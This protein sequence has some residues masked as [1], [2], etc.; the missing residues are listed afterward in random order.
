M[1]GRACNKVSCSSPSSFVLEAYGHRSPFALISFAEIRLPTID[2]TPVA[3]A[4]RH[5][6]DRGQIVVYGNVL[7]V[8]MHDRGRARTE[9]HRR[10]VRIAVEETR[11]RGALTATDLGGG[12]GNLLV[13]LGDGFHD[14]MIPRDF[15]RL[16]VIPH[17]AH[18]RRVELHPRILGCGACHLLHEA[19][20]HTLVVLSRNRA[21]AALQKAVD[22]KGARIVAGGEAADNARK[23]IEGI[24]IERVSDG[25]DPLCLQLCDRLRDLVAELNSADAL[26]ALLNAGGF[27]VDFDLKPDPAD[28]CGLYRQVAGLA[29]NAGVSLVATDHR[30]QRAVAADFFVDDDI[31]V[32]VALGLEARGQE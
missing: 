23:R 26:V 28:A 17:E 25:R 30:I 22:G 11:I 8:G 24:G 4:E 3:D 32:N 10:G 18:L 31:D 15:G 21:D 14:G 2:A 7:V 6:L 16:R 1:V 27:A 13:V 29:G 9:D 19:L 20:L 12:A 5:N